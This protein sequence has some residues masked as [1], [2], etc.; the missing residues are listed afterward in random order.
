MYSLLFMILIMLTHIALTCLVH[1]L[2]RILQSYLCLFI[3]DV[4]AMSLILI[5]LPSICLI[6]AVGN[7]P[8][9]YEQETPIVQQERQVLSEWSTDDV[10]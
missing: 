5:T 4:Y 9:P 1:V 6:G 2:Y 10:M 3:N 7:E 8:F